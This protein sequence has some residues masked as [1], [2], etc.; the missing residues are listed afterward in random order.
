MG[1][2]G[3]RT[4][5]RRGTAKVRFESGNYCRSTA[6]LTDAQSQGTKVASTVARD[7]KI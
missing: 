2:Q 6:L 5:Y 3:C 7:R 4:L 1:A